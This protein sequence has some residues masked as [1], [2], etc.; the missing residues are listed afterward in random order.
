MCTWSKS[1]RYRIRVTK[2]VVFAK[3]IFIFSLISICAD[4]QTNIQ[5]IIQTHNFQTRVC[6]ENKP[7]G[8]TYTFYSVRWATE[9][10]D[11]LGVRAQK[12]AQLRGGGTNNFCLWSGYCLEICKDLSSIVHDFWLCGKINRQTNIQTN[13]PLSFDYVHKPGEYN[14]CSW[15]GYCLEIC[16]DLSPVVHDFWLCGKINRQTNRQ[17]NKHLRLGCVDNPRGPTLKV[18]T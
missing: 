14:F 1:G 16:K 11:I 6:S 12:V 9:K 5:T 17:T 8:T 10:G 2:V 3:P 15:S 18:P 13:K 4:I 7:L